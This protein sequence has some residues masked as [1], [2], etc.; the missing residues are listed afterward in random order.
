MLA[1]VVTSELPA[2]L[3]SFIA[4]N[5]ASVEQLEILLRL[6]EQRNQRWSAAELN[7]DL[8]SQEA[9]VARWLGVLVSLRLA[10]HTDGGFQFQPDP[11]EQEAQVAALAA[12]YRERP[13]RVIEAIFAKPNSQLLSFA[14][15]FD[16]RKRP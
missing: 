13:I 2:D 6:Y 1:G 16:L 4:R 11:P 8:R 15:A 10:A 3:R 14:Q 5:I 12:I 7:R 9:S